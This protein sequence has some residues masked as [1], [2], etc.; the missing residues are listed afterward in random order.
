MNKKVRIGLL[1]FVVIALIG[2]PQASAYY[3]TEFLAN[4]SVRGTVLDT[5]EVCHLID[6][7]WPARN[8]YGTDFELYGHNFT[9]IENLD[10]DGDGFTNIQEI[11]E[12]TFPGNASSHP[13]NIMVNV[14]IVPATLNLNSHINYITGYI[15]LPRGYYFKTID[16]KSITLGAGVPGVDPKYSGSI[17]PTEEVIGDFDNDGVQ[18]MMLK[19]DTIKV[20]G[21]LGQNGIF[22]EKILNQKIDIIITGKFLD[23]KTTLEGR[24]TMRVMYKGK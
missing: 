23:Q 13:E 2:I 11:S 19:F 12:L 5:C 9:N 8:P 14:Q 1:L 6:D 17:I 22:K 4:Y 21:L 24:D 7:S 16:M 10:S 20:V 15:E 18:E 3:R